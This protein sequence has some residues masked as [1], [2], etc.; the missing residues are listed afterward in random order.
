[1]LVIPLNL[2]H[3]M[4]LILFLQMMRLVVALVPL[5]LTLK[6]MLFVYPILCWLHLLQAPKPEPA[7]LPDQHG[8]LQLMPVFHQPA[9]KDNSTVLHRRNV[10]QDE[11]LVITP[12]VSMMEFAHEKNL[13]SVQIVSTDEQMT[14]TSVVS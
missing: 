10:S 6:R 5:V 9:E 1:M 11:A 12:S 14:K 7:A 2:A 3:L 8:I 4:L 13:V